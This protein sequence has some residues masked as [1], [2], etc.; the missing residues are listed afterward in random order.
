MLASGPFSL[1]TFARPA[2]LPM[3]LDDYHGNFGLRASSLRLDTLEHNDDGVGSALGRR[4]SLHSSGGFLGLHPD[5]HP[6]RPL[7]TEKS[8]LIHQL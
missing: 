1:Q 7:K 4:L 5:R 8:D 6:E 3:R 2:N